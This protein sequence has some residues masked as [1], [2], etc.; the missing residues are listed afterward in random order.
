MVDPDGVILDRLFS[1]ILSRRGDDPKESYV[2][3]QFQSGTSRIAQKV[4]EEAIETVLAALS[5]DKNELISESADLLFHLMV[6][7]ADKGLVPSDIY[8]E[9]IRREGVSGLDAKKAG[10]GK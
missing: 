2:A 7:W 4:G 10:K 9:L 3:Q 6:L 5:N 8:A 1:V